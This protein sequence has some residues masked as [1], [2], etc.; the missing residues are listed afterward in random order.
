MIRITLLTWMFSHVLACK[1]DGQQPLKRADS[2]PSASSNLHITV[3]NLTLA[4]TSVLQIKTPVKPDMTHMTYEVCPK[5]GTCIQ[6]KTP[7]GVIHLADL[8]EGEGIVTVGR[9]MRGEPCK[10]DFKKRYRLQE[11]ANRKDRVV[12]AVEIR[13]R[14]DAKLL[15]FCEDLD[16]VLRGAQDSPKWTPYTEAIQAFLN[17][18][19]DRCFVLLRSGMLTHLLAAGY[20]RGM[21]LESM[22]LMPLF[23][24]TVAEQELRASSQDETLQL[25]SDSEER[26]RLESEKAAKKKKLARNMTKK[27][28]LR[29]TILE[30]RKKLANGGMTAISLHDVEL[31]SLR[32]TR[33]LFASDR[34]LEEAQVEL[35]KIEKGETATSERGA[36]LTPKQ[37]RE[38]LGLQRNRVTRLTTERK[39]VVMTMMR[40]HQLLEG[41]INPTSTHQEVMAALDQVEKDVQEHADRETVLK[42]AEKK[43]SAIWDEIQGIDDRLNRLEPLQ[44]NHPPEPTPS[45]NIK[46]GKPALLTAGVGLAVAAS[47]AL[48]Y[49][50]YKNK[51]KDDTMDGLGLT[52]TVR[53]KLLGYLTRYL[54]IVAPS[55]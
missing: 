32:K 16:G 1:T 9:C 37:R 5:D 11:S 26:T 31:D 13:R 25:S 19:P 54:D 52:K 45:R 22:A 46:L 41:K 55:I 29:A 4:E 12:Q 36:E 39:K 27:D 49:A 28:E 33:T 6:G 24:A 48:V 18:G 42:K 38:L 43:I 53:N 47:I 10:S 8:P 7:L 23:I 20:E 50:L 17:L 34:R 44:V 30:V 14:K 2:P 35:A 40:T 15:K 51:K 3:D 21:P